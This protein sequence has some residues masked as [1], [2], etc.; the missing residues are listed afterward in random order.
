VRAAGGVLRQHL[1]QHQ[2][3]LEHGGGVIQFELR[4]Q[5]ELGQERQC[6]GDHRLGGVVEHRQH[7]AL[8]RE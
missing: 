7:L 4:Q 5:F 8:E 1:G 3:R 2:P 6:V